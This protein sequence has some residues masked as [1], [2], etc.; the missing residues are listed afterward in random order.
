MI[1]LGD[2]HGDW[3]NLNDFINKKQPTNVIICGDFGYWPNFAKHDLKKIKNHNTNIYWCPGNHES[4][5][6]LNKIGRIGKD[7]IEIH[8]RI[9]YCPI[10][11]TKTLEGKKYIFLGGADSIDKDF[12]TLGVDYFDTE[13]LTNGDITKIEEMYNNIYPEVDTVISHTCPTFISEEIK[14]RKNNSFDISRCLAKSEDPT[15]HAL[16][17]LFDKL[18]PKQW[19]F[20]HWHFYIQLLAKECNFIGLDYIKGNSK[21]FEKI[22][23]CPDCQLDLLAMKFNLIANMHDI[24]KEYIDIINEHFW[25]LI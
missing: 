25:D 18:K 23:P 24:P 13:T 22:E 16:D 10:G 11:S 5:D 7:P 1:I 8:P 14:Y 2:T 19:Y 3:S 21:Y 4:W 12:R 15:C 20:G 9:F 17:Y 6:A